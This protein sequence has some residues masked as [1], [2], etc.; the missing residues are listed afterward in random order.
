MLSMSR[1]RRSLW[2]DPGKV[3]EV[4][5][6]MM[7][8][9]ED[10]EDGVVMLLR[11]VLTEDEKMKLIG[12]DHIKQVKEE[13]SDSYSSVEAFMLKTECESRPPSRSIL[14][15]VDWTGNGND[16]ASGQLEQIRD[17]PFENLEAWPLS[18]SLIHSPRQEEE[19]ETQLYPT[20]VSGKESLPSSSA[21]VLRN[22][23]NIPTF[24]PIHKT[25][26]RASG[27]RKQSSEAKRKNRGNVSQ[28]Q[29]NEKSI[30]A[31]KRSLFSGQE[32]DSDKDNQ[33]EVGKEGE[34]PDL[35]VVEDKLPELEE[36]GELPD[37]EVEDGELPDLEG[38]K[39]ARNKIPIEP[40]VLIETYDDGADLL[41]KWRGSFCNRALLIEILRMQL[42]GAAVD[43]DD[44][45]VLES[46]LVSGV[47]MESE[48]EEGPRCAEAAVASLLP[49]DIGRG[50]PVSVGR[51]CLLHFAKMARGPQSRLAALLCRSQTGVPLTFVGRNSRGELIFSTT[52]SLTKCGKTLKEVASSLTQLQAHYQLPARVRSNRL[53]LTFLRGQDELSPVPRSSYTCYW[54]AIRCP[55]IS[56]LGKIKLVF[57]L[58]DI[59]SKEPE[60][61]E[62]GRQTFIGEYFGV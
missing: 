22:V 61:K 26:K 56:N 17:S 14:E 7:A 57:C 62:R 47:L 41:P 11:K 29:A 38:E 21:A 51:L 25:P 45:H 34:L 23:G 5:E 36:D 30:N 12:H 48:R 54:K 58:T 44:E 16:V 37:L 20:L 35:E 2:K 13:E 46:F 28:T 33:S 24:D 59:K 31:I 8:D 40:E 15:E 3:R 42:A 53:E 43:L 50:Q 19:E 32:S 49:T 1:V 27:E 6:A 60:E 55:D 52:R 4:M 18:Q 9:K 39:G 10:K